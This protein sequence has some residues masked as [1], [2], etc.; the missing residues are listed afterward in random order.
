M[1]LNHNLVCFFLSDIADNL[2]LKHLESIDN[3]YTIE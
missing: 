1:W 2:C 3:S